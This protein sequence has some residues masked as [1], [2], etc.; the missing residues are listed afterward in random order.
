MASLVSMKYSSTTGIEMM[1]NCKKIISIKKMI[2]GIRC[3]DSFFLPHP[4]PVATHGFPSM[5]LVLLEVS[6]C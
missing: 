3:N 5:C 6:C 1:N 2:Y 4:Q